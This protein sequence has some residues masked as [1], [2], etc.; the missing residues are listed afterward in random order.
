M[1]YRDDFNE[2]DDGFD[3]DYEDKFEDIEFL[4]PEDDGIDI[5]GFYDDEMDDDYEEFDDEPYEIKEK[6]PKKKL[7]K[8]AII[9]RAMAIAGVIIMGFTIFYGTVAY[10]VFH[11]TTAATNN[12]A[13]KTEEGE[14]FFTSPYTDANVTE[15]TKQ[16]LNNAALEPMLTNYTEVDNAVQGVLD[17]TVKDEMTTYEKVRNIYDYLMYTYDVADT[18]FIDEDSVYSF[19]SKYEYSS[20][21]D[22]E[23][24]Y[25]GNQAITNKSGDTKDIASV[26]ALA[27]RRIGLQAYYIDADS[28]V[29]GYSISHGYVVVSIYGDY[30]V[31]DPAAEDNLTTSLGT[32]ENSYAFFCKTFGELDES[33]VLSE[34]EESMEEFNEFKTLGDFGFAVTISTSSGDST[35][36]NVT[37]E[38]GSA[39]SASA[40]TIKLEAG[41]RITF[42]GTVTGSETNTWK[43]VADVNDLSGNYINEV[44]LYNET[45]SEASDTVS[46]YP[47]KGGIINLMFM[48]TDENGRTC[49]VTC[50]AEVDGDD[51]YYRP[52]EPETEEETSTTLYYEETTQETTVYYDET[53]NEV[54]TYEEINDD[55]SQY[56]ETTAPETTPAETTPAETTPAE[57]TPAET[58]P[59]ETTPAESTTVAP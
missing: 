3:D 25:R 8:D 48:V 47:S 35:S 42:K 53:T 40:D 29:D 16:V 39:A 50:R 6:G 36:A 43:L 55:D 54:T 41:D 31:F 59:A 52:T 11:K 33:Y 15:E 7:S 12:K 28:Y 58:T 23:L 20:Y 30:Y 45:H 46:Y 5:D 2:F 21:F 44:T 19:C 26:F 51:T 38:S 37:Y 24:M 56:D 34:A 49:T 4:D 57:T 22:M 27:L 1:K 14:G 32:N 17:V 9:N 18:S 13:A 10:S